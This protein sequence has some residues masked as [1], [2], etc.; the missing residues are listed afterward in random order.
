M[1]SNKSNSNGN[2]NA[3][4]LRNISKTITNFLWNIYNSANSS[5]VHKTSK[6]S[7]KLV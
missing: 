2:S 1:V 4:K 5:N 6:W 7:N 3:N